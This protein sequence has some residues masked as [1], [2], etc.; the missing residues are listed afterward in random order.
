MAKTSFVK[1]SASEIPV[2]VLP[3]EQSTETAVAIREDRQIAAPAARFNPSIQGEFNSSDIG[4]PFL[5]LAN[6]TGELGEIFTPGSFV[7]NKKVALS[8]GIDALLVTV[9]NVRK[10]YIEDIAFGSDVRPEIW[11]TTDEVHAAGGSLEWGSD[12]YYKPTADIKLIVGKPDNE[13]NDSEFPLVGPDGLDYAIAIWSV[14]GGAYTSGA[15]PIFAAALSPKL[16]GGLH[17]VTFYL[18]STKK[19]KDKNIWFAPI[20]RQ[21]KMHSEEF[22]AFASEYV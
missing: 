14:K 21:G 2:E 17:L 7:L 5:S 11:E 3:P 15:K 4:F 20:S 6:K 12:R 13:E 18:T 1:K 10:R 16:A 8:N 19:Q 9:L 22:A